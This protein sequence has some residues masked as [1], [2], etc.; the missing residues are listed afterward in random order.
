M[1]IIQKLKMTINETMQLNPGDLIDFR[2]FQGT[3]FCHLVSAAIQ[4]NTHAYGID[5]FE[6]LPAPCKEDMGSSNYYIHNKGL[7]KSNEVFTKRNIERLIKKPS[8]YSIIKGNLNSAIS[9]IN[10]SNISFGLIDLYQ[11]KPTKD[12]LDYLWENINYGGT[13][14]ILNYNKDNDNSSD[15]AITKFINEHDEH[16]IFNHQLIINGLKQNHL[17]IK[18]FNENKKPSNWHTPIDIKSKNNLTVALVLKTGGVYTSDYVNALANG[19]RKYSTIDFELACITDNAQGFN[20]KIDKVIPFKHDYPKWWGKI[21]LFR[22]DLFSDNRVFFLD[23]DTI[24]IKNIDDI[25]KLDVSFAGLRDFYHMDTLGSGLLAWKPS[26]EIHNIY[27]KFTI[28]S[29]SI[30]NSYPQGDQRW[31][32]ENVRNINYF[33]DIV[34]NKIVSFKKNCLKQSVIS[35]PN[36]ASIICFHGIPRP[37]MVDDPI[38]RNYWNP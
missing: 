10:S 37:H 2:I 12:A 38:I 32:N 25:L 8:N 17:I 23:L 3:T 26:E 20:N 7:L 36:N 21:E 27:K 34:P 1:N 33:Q 11:Y 30:I 4:Y 9:Q 28:Q 29:N 14:F 24:I 22:P 19:L 18:C 5:T 35:I 6:G 31:I 16:I 13:I 15:L